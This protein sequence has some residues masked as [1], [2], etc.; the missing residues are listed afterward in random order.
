LSKLATSF[1]LG[2]HGCDKKLD[3]MALTGE[4]SLLR[5]D[6]DY[7]WLGPGVYF[8]E[9]DPGRAREWA[10]E[11]VARG[12]YQ[13]PFVIGAVIDLGNCLDLL[14]RENVDWLKVAYNSLVAS[15]EMSG[16]ALPRN[17]DKKG[18]RTGDKLLRFLDCAVIRRLH[19]ILEQDLEHSLEGAEVPPPFDTVRGL[20]TEGEAVY[21]DVGFYLKTHTQIAVR[22]DT[23]IKGVFLPR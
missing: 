10:E 9:G 4:L 6:K 21:P 14:V 3:K 22:N 18:D 7:D 19:A 2:Y 16:Q 15:H 8:W 23:C 17:K 20:F 5:S 13:K 12:E 11:K 1:V